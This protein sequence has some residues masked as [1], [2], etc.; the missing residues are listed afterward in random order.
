MLIPR[1][2]AWTLLAGVILSGIDLASAQDFP[3]KPIRL[4]IG[5]PPG[6][7]ADTVARLI[8]PKLSEQLGQQVVIDNRAGA[9]GNIALELLAKSPP[10][11]YSLMLTTPTVTVN[12]ALYAKPG[13]D[14][15][16]D[17]APV[18]LMATTIYVLVVHPSLPVKSVKELV[19][20]ARAKPR[21]LFYSSGGNG[22]AAHLSLE[23]FRSMAR[24]EIVHVPY[25]GIAPA[26]IALLS[27]EVQFSSGSPTSTLP[28]IK[29]GRLRALAVTSAGRSAF[30]PDLPSISEAGVPGY[31]TTAWYGTLAPARTPRPIIDKL[32][33]AFLAVIALPDIRAS[34]HGQSFEI[35]PSTPEAFSALIRSELGKW[36]KIV[37]DSG[38]R[39]E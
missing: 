35:T 15:V 4:I 31:E 32:N 7:G 14:P 28:F 39:V 21:Q 33:A 3:A 26:L 27:G 9:S 24:I 22:S 23:L 36:G 12:P 19:A 5:F 38:M 25:K 6:G 37:K 13:Y 29:E 10:D 20:L 18:A 17:F 34:L 11:G 1:F 30:V 8:V 2:A 16:N